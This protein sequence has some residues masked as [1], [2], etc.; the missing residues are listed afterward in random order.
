VSHEC[1]DLG[2][3][4]TA[5]YRSGR[6]GLIEVEHHFEEL[7]ELHDLIERG[8][9]WNTLAEIVIRLN[10]HRVAYPNDTIEAAD[11]R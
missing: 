11:E 10:P 1:E 8:P 5:V 4:A 9:D 6:L 7:T 2:W 3:I